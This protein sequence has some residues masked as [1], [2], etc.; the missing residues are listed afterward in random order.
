MKTVLE[1]NSLA[2][3]ILQPFEFSTD[4]VA[5]QNSDVIILSNVS[6]D[7]LSALQMDHIESYVRDLGKG[8]VIIGGDRASAGAAITTHHWN[9]Y[10][11]LT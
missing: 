5:L 3:E 4:F 11:P 2:V 10:H 1:M 8:L 9:R 6:A 7:K